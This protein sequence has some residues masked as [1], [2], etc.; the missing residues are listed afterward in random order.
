MWPNKTKNR[1]LQVLVI[2]VL[3]GLVVSGC[4]RG[5]ASVATYEGGKVSLNQLNTYLGA[6]KFFNFDG[7]EGQYAKRMAD[8]GFKEGMLRR[9]IAFS[10]LSSTA[11]DKAKQESSK[12]A[13]VQLAEVKK[14]IERQPAPNNDLNA[15]LKGLAI[16]ADDLE[17]YIELQL[18]ASAAMSKKFPDDKVKAEYDKAIKENKY[19]YIDDVTVRHILVAFKDAEGKEKLTK[20]AALTRAKEVKDKLDNGGDF[21][22]LAKEYSDDGNKDT[23][24]IYEHANPN[25]WVEAFKNASLELPI[26]EISEP[27]ETEYGYHVMK[28]E[29]RNSNKYEDVKE[30]IRGN[31]IQAFFGEYMTKEIPK[32]IKKINIPGVTP[33][34]AP[35]VLPSVA[36]TVVPTAAATTAPST[37]PAP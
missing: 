13:K 12:K 4:A 31:F 18:N 11:D 3:I 32:I 14:S 34:P 5:Y 29:S 30:K 20:E 24:G 9:Y 19:A 6:D 17:K 36:P 35:R 33:A 2:I 8:P 22:A 28:V 21:A 37:T 23:G 7:E 1:G 27:V 26:N 10:K 16:S 15:I 25:Q